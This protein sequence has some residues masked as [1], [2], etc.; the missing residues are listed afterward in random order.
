LAYY[1]K[2]IIGYGN[3]KKIKNKN[4]YLFILSNKDGIL[5]VLNLINGKLRTNNKFN[6]V[7]NNILIHPKYNKENLDFNINNTNDFNNH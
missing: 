1:I 2:K 3:V 4:A 5:K 6:Q 7:I